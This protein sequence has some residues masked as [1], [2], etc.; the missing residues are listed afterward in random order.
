MKL[1]SLF[2]GSGGFCLGGVLAGITPVWASEIEPF[3]IAVTRARFPDVIHYGDVS[4]LD[5]AKIEPVDVITFGSPCT[6]LS[7]AGKR[8]GLAGKQSGLFHQAIRIIKE[9][10][11]ATNG[12]YPRFAVWENV[13]GAFSSNRGEDFRCVLQELVGIKEQVHVPKPDKWRRGGC[14]MGDGYS[15]AWRTLDAQYWGVPQRRKRIYLVADF[16]GASA[17]E[18]LFKR[19]SN[20]W[21]LAASQNTRQGTADTAGEGTER[22][23]LIL[24]DQG[25]SVIRV[26]ENKTD[27]LRAETKGHL[28]V[29]L[30]NH[31]EDNRCT[32]CENSPT[33]TN[34][35]GTGGN[36]KPLVWTIDRAAYNQGV[37]AQFN[38][39]IDES[40]IT[41]TVVAKGPN[42]V[43]YGVGRGG[44][45][46]VK[47]MKQ[48]YTLTTNNPDPRQLRFTVVCYDVRFTSDGTKNSRG[49]VYETDTSRTID[50]N[51]T[52]PNSNH[53]GVA[54]IEGN[55]SRPSHQG[56]GYSMNDK[57]Y[58]LNTVE[59]HGVAYNKGRYIIR[60]LTPLECCRLQGF[61]DGW[62]DNIAVT[63]PSEEDMTFWRGIFDTQCEIK[64]I[65]KKT[66]NQIKK[67]LT[68]PYSDSACYR[69]WG[70][71]VALP[72][73]EFVLSGIAEVLKNET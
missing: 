49:N 24:N 61:P 41:Q 46:G 23:N 6:D 8:A 55:G 14:V 33:L 39:Q 2:D 73:V 7:I 70:N 67:F 63:N 28:P 22:P 64:G 27:T 68:K 5:G 12:T 21:Y 56:E 19:E 50:T 40:E 25:D 17:P 45:N 42:A 11:I 3:P 44:L 30:D 51:I 60:A 57:S 32:I 65:K 48:S 1:G 20:E 72:C 54:V 58:T 9:M 62:T 15:V 69:M 4:A 13:L 53:G 31:P 52:N 16:R 37:N 35:M 29:I 47:E 59:K 34:K 36:N 26:S 43:C 71:G 38:I 10:R 18:I 66:D